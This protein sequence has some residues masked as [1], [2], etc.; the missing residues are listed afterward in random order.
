MPLDGNVADD[1]RTAAEKLRLLAE[2][3]ETLAPDQLDLR[4][5]HHSC[6]AAHCA[7]GWGEMI[8][9]FPR[10]EGEAAGSGRII[11]AVARRHRMLES[12]R[13]VRGEKQA[14]WPPT[15]AVAGAVST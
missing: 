5:V 9:L 6:G 4:T 8:G 14:P 7:W 2:F 15:D 13:K 1:R 3:M 12:F 10:P 11:A